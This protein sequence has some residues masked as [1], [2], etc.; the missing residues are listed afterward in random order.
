MQLQF[1][2]N[3]NAH[4]PYIILVSEL[5]LKNGTGFKNVCTWIQRLTQFLIYSPDNEVLH[6]VLEYIIQIL[7]QINH[8]RFNEEKTLA[9]YNLFAIVLKSADQNNSKHL[10]QAKLMR[11]VLFVPNIRENVAPHAK[12][13]S[14]KIR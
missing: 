2:L 9:D 4:D 3:R 5:I 10:T 12:R 7:I 1:F 11:S 8:P 13:V 14:F 6:F